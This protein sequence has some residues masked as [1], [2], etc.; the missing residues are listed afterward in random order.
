MTKLSE[1]IPERNEGLD[2]LRRIF[3]E[4]NIDISEWVTKPITKERGGIE[5]MLPNADG[6]IYLE[7]TDLFKVNV[8][9]VQSKNVY[10]ETLY[11]LGDL[12]EI[13]KTL[14]NQR[15]SFIGGLRDM[16]FREFSKDEEE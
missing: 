2:S 4:L 9:F 1:G 15:K 3:N 13:I 16:L 11:Q 7:W 5:F 8:T 14:E 10:N 6:E 12:Y